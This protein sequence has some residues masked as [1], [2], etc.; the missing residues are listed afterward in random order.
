LGGWCDENDCVEPGQVEAA[1]RTA[2]CEELPRVSGLEAGLIPLRTFPLRKWYYANEL[3]YYH[4]PAFEHR[5]IADPK[6]F[7]LVD[8]QLRELCRCLLSAGLRTS[9][10][11]QG[12][13]H[14]RERFRR[15]WDELSHE[16]ELIR[17]SGLLVRDSESEEPFAFSEPEYRLAWP[18]FASFF[19][20]ASRQQQHGYIG[21]AI[22][23]G[24]P[25][26]VARF[27]D[28]RVVLDGVRIEPDT[29]LGGIFGQPFVSVSVESRSREQRD[30]AWAAVTA[31]VKGLLRG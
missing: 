25:E 11:C 31:H 16:E 13:F 17:S 15:V 29:E 7:E 8:P 27:C 6:F 5:L 30:A 2:S 24:Q 4:A 9:P 23:N 26:L 1:D 18:D 14:S 3:W 22:P 21:I 28:H 12:H 10:S 19:E 20:Q